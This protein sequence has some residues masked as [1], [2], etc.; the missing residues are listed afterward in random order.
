MQ[1]HVLFYFKFLIFLK[2]NLFRLSPKMKQHEEQSHGLEQK[3]S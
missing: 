2:K 3:H 1:S